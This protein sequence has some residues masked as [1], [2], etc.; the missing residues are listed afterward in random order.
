MTTINGAFQ[1]FRL[2]NAAD[3]VITQLI[4]PLANNK[5]RLTSLSYTPGATAHDLIIMRA[6]E[7]VEAAVAAAAAATSLELTSTT[8]VGDT[9]ANGDYIVVEHSDDT[10]GL[11]LVSALAGSTVTINALSKAVNAN[12]SVWIL[13]APGESYHSTLGTIASTR[14]DFSDE[15][16]GLAQTGY[17]DGTYNRDG[18]G[19]PMVIY[20]SNATAAGTLNRG[21]ATYVSR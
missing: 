10:Y 5:V 2:S 16:G 21:A 6:L 19:D 1:F 14:M 4:P 20:S 18:R 3:T 15:A 8:F 7:L 12:A 17:D 11:Y 9:I 13:G